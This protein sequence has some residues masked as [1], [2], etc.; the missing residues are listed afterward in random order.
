MLVGNE[1]VA[2]SLVEDEKQKYNVIVNGVLMRSN[3]PRFIAESYIRTLTVNEQSHASMIP[4]T[5]EGKEIL[6]G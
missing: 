2:P 4:I 6:F 5:N 3:V 1:N